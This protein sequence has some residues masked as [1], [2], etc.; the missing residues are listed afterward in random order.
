[1]SGDQLRDGPDRDAVH[2]DTVE[3]LL[4][5]LVSLGVDN[6][7]VELNSPKCPSWM[8]APRRSSI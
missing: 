7:L 2:I 1:M 5:A 8:G 6:V 4:S 3:H